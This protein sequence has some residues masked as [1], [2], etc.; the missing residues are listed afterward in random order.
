MF[1]I[2]PTDSPAIETRSAAYPFGEKVPSKVLMLRT[3][4]PEAPLY[5]EPQHYPIAYIGT[6]YP[7]FV[8]SNGELAV[9]LP[10]GQLMHVPHD[11]FMVVGFHSG[12]ADTNR[13]KIFLS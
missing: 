3:C 9:I 13:A 12:L 11:A 4:V 7:C 10:S 2:A 6:R 5:V 1:A 8:E